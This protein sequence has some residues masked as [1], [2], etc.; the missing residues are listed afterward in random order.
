MEVESIRLLKPFVV[1]LNCCRGIGNRVGQP[2]RRQLF[3]TKM[4]RLG[5]SWAELSRCT[6]DCRRQPAMPI[7][8]SRPRRNRP[9]LL[10]AKT[11]S[12]LARSWA[13]IALTWPIARG[14]RP[15]RELTVGPGAVGTPP[16]QGKT[17][18]EQSAVQVRD[19]LMHDP[20]RSGWQR[21]QVTSE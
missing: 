8:N 5:C 10:S 11:I 2:K 1:I 20:E 14:N 7:A 4:G 13:E 15:C 17:I 18:P 19:H 6:A 21:T 16:P 9:I 3:K 12:R